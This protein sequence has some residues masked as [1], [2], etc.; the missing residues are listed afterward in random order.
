MMEPYMNQEINNN[1]KRINKS[2][3]NITEELKRS[4]DLKEKELNEKS[5]RSEKAK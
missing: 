2:L 5:E 1:L 4:N 3:G